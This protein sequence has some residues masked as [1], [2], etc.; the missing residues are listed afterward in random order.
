M[1]V[2]TRKTLEAWRWSK[3]AKVAPSIW[4]DGNTIFSYGTAVAVRIE[5]STSVIFNTTKY[6]PTTSRH[7][8]GIGS[9]LRENLYDVIEV[10]EIHRGAGQ[11]ALEAAAVASGRIA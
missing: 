5:G 10:G 3:A 1:R 8:S 2:N 7:Q 4:T 9:Y 6:S 11:Y